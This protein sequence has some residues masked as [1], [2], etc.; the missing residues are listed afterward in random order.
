MVTIILFSPLSTS[1]RA[2]AREY[3]H[4]YPLAYRLIFPAGFIGYKKIAFTGI[5]H[6]IPVRWR[7][8]LITLNPAFLPNSYCVINR[9]KL[10]FQ[11]QNNKLS[12]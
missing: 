5:R 12:F 9:F 11:L 4:R 6:S 10:N 8:V 7:R 3:G 1:E 2:A